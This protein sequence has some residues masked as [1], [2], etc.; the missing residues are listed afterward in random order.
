VEVLKDI[1]FLLSYVPTKDSKEY[2]KIK[3]SGKQQPLKTHTFSVQVQSKDAPAMNQFLRKVYEDKNLFVP[4]LMQKS[5]Q[6]V[7]RV[8]QKQDKCIK[9]MG[10][11][12]DCITQEMMPKLE[13]IAETKKVVGISD[14]KALTHSSDPR[15][16]QE[17]P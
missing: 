7:A 9:D 5:P 12:A 10:G 13:I 17:H 2:V 14:T 6:A 15:L 16:L 3:L 8:F 1:G 4:Y 11:C